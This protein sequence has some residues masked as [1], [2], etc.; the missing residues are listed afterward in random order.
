MR[1]GERDAAMMRAV[2]VSR[3][4]ANGGGGGAG[5]H[6]DADRQTDKCKRGRTSKEPRGSWARGNLGKGVCSAECSV[7]IAECS[8]ARAPYIH[9]YI[10]TYY[11]TDMVDANA[12]EKK[13]V[14]SRSR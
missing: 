5:G 6:R 4:G 3:A 7:Q 10:L 8:R 9:T 12:K 11:S 13:R 14:R 2:Y 1:V